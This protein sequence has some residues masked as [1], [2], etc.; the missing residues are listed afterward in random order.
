MVSPVARGCIISLQD[1]DLC[2]Q[3]FARKTYGYSLTIPFNENDA[4]HQQIRSQAIP[5][6]LDTSAS[7]FELP[8]RAIWEIPEGS[9]VSETRN[10]T[11]QGTFQVPQD[12]VKFPHPLSLSIIATSD[13]EMA[14]RNAYWDVESEEVKGKI[15][16]VTELTV[17]I[18]ASDKFEWYNHPDHPGDQPF[19]CIAFVLDMT[20]EGMKTEWELFVPRTKD[21]K[22]PVE[23]DSAWKEDPKRALVGEESLKIA[24]RHV[25]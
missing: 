23:W 10:I 22:I 2:E 21:G 5:A 7:G 19:L 9:R 8:T 3:T 16:K 20:L 24:T 14:A 11:L 1:P 6:E 4:L 17:L 15:E 25:V 18:K 13:P 12:L